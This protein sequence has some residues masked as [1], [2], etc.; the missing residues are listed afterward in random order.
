MKD[1]THIRILQLLKDNPNG[2]TQSEIAE[3]LDLE[4]NSIDWA[5]EEAGNAGKILIR[6]GSQRDGEQLIFLG[7]HGR[8][9]LL[10]HSELIES[11]ESSADAKK[12]AIWA[13]GIAIIVGIAQIL[14]TIFSPS[15]LNSKQF[16][17]LLKSQP[18]LE[19]TNGKLDLIK[20]SLQSQDTLLIRLN[21][22]LIDSLK[23]E[24]KRLPPTKPKKH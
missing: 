11:R 6:T 16:Q 1:D 23:K 9:I 15:T 12:I 17:E 18:N 3:K 4:R 14:I 22:E 7:M 13:L 5:Y 20:E 8:S 24:E 10:Q 2:L 19:Q 21:S